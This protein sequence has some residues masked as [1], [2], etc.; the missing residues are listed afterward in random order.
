MR[1]GNEVALKLTA[2]YVRGRPLFHN[3]QGTIMLYDLL[4]QAKAFKDGERTMDSPVL[5]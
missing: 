2:L 3:I 5:P 4:F 1:T